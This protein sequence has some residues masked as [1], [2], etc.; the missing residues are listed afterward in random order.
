M[1]EHI[2]NYSPRYI[3]MYDVPLAPMQP[4]SSQNGPFGF[5]QTLR[6]PF[7]DPTYNFYSRE[8]QSQAF[9]PR[10]QPGLAGHTAEV[11]G[12]DNTN[13]ETS[14]RKAASCRKDRDRPVTGVALENRRKQARDRITR[15]GWKGR[16]ASMA[17]EYTQ[18]RAWYDKCCS[19]SGIKLFIKEAE[20]LGESCSDWDAIRSFL[21]SNIH[22]FIAFHAMEKD[23]MVPGYIIR[24][25]ERARADRTLIYPWL[26][27][28]IREYQGQGQSTPMS[29]VSAYRD[30]DVEPTAGYLAS[31]PGRVHQGKSSCE[32]AVPAPASVAM[33]SSPGQR[34]KTPSVETVQMTPSRKD[35]HRKRQ[36]ASEE[37]EEPAANDPI[38]KV[39]RESTEA[40][41]L[42]TRDNG[43]GA[44]IVDA[45]VGGTHD[46]RVQSHTKGRTLTVLFHGMRSEGAAESEH[47]Q[48]YVPRTSRGV[49]INFL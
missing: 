11:A 3:G 42:G 5:S 1:A 4:P 46:C 43:H 37:T 10:S 32:L 17:I 49:T 6:Q 47:V 14:Q 2:P 24:K 28:F 34:S 25:A 26:Y 38:K 45:S 33:N 16:I 9:E 30:P 31:S 7:H 23:F 36:L 12:N 48:V 13:T 19:V 21:D 15:G 44:D 27:S 8:H 39:K 18:K 40:D 35:E 20:K 41:L 22:R 29:L